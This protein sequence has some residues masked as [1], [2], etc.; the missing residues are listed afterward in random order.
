MEKSKN[1]NKLDV[2]TFLVI[3]VMITISALTTI[4]TW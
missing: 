2:T 1:T 4:A 3:L